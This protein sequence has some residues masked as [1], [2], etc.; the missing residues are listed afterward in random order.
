MC[1]YLRLG[2]VRREGSPC[3]S[4]T[5]FSRNVFIRPTISFDRLFIDL[6]GMYMAL[7]AQTH[8][9]AILFNRKRPVASKIV[10]GVS[11]GFVEAC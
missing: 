6:R 8:Y 9:P 7:L 10:C 2:E 11:E 3:L 4:Y 5:Y 1:W